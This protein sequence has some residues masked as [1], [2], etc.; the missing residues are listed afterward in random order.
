MTV[1][2]ISQL[3]IHDR[4]EY[5]KYE[6]QF[7]EV[8]EPFGGSVLSVDEDPKVLSG[9]WTATRSVLLEFPSAERAY[10]WMTSDDY[11]AIA[12]HRSAGA[13][14]TSIMVKGQKPA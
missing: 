10:A 5:S 12:K 4:D 13:S 8:F 11:S 7:M 14:L 9:E 3:K 6:S 2:I 1:Y